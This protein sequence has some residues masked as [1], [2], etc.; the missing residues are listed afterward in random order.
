MTENGD[1]DEV[2]PWPAT[3]EDLVAWATAS[4][5]Q[6]S[7]DTGTLLRLLGQ[8]RLTAKTA[9]AVEEWLLMLSRQSGATLE[10]LA[11]VTG[12]SPKYVRGPDK[13]LQRLAEQYGTPEAR[14]SALRARIRGT[15]DGA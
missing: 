3:P 12:A 14:L 8:A 15:E 11:E 1:R 9:T 7:P 13:R 5:Q 4:E 10:Q 6:G 2:S